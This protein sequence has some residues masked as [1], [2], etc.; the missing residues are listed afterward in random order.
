MRGCRPSNIFKAPALGAASTAFTCRPWITIEEDRVCATGCA[1]VFD[2]SCIR[3]RKIKRTAKHIWVCGRCSRRSRRIRR[4]SQKRIQ[5]N[6]RPPDTRDRSIVGD[7]IELTI[8]VAVDIDNTLSSNTSPGDCAIIGNGH[9]V[10][11]S[12]DDTIYALENPCGFHIDDNI[13]LT[14]IDENDG[15]FVLRIQVD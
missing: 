1:C 13:I 14:I 3:Q 6:R 15:V 4:G 10:A 9:R 2:R 5:P 11:L 12:E 7:R 8:G